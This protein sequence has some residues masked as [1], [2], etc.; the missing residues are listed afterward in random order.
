MN[1][2]GEGSCTVQLARVHGIHKTPWWQAPFL[3]RWD[4]QSHLEA[5]LYEPSPHGAFLRGQAVSLAPWNF[6]CRNLDGDPRATVVYD[7]LWELPLR[8]E[9][10]WKRPAMNSWDFYSVRMHLGMRFL[11]WTGIEAEHTGA[12]M[13][14]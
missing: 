1:G 8:L 9:K 10:V 13:A 5:H 12:S 7:A 2:N 4:M 14:F 6:I 3:A 11:P